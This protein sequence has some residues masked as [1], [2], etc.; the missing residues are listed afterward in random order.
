MVSRFRGRLGN[1]PISP[2]AAPNR[3][4]LNPLPGWERREDGM[5]SRFR[6][7]TEDVRKGEGIRG[8]GF[9]L[10]RERE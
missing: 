5:D 6:G 2:T 4:H 3:P 7:K 8:D 9:P 1:L 10:L